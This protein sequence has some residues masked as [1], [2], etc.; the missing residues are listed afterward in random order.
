SKTLSQRELLACSYA[1]QSRAV[2][3]SELYHQLTGAHEHGLDSA[4]RALRKLLQN[5]KPSLAMV[6]AFAGD[7]AAKAHVMLQAAV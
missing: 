1:L 2:N 4:A 5:Q 7:D 6:F 3:L